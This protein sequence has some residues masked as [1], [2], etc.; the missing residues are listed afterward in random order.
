MSCRINH[1]A[2][3]FTADDGAGFFHLRHH[4][5]LT[6]GSGGVVA[7]VFFGHIAQTTC[8]G[9]VTYGVTGRVLEHIV[10]HGHEGVFF[11]E[12][13]TVFANQGEAVGVGI[14]HKTDVV[15][16]F[17]HEVAN[18]AEI[19]LERF[20]VVCKIA[21]GFAVQQGHLRHAELPEQLGNDDTAH[22]VHCVEGNSEVRT[23][24]GFHVDKLELLDQFNVTLV[25]AVVLNETTEVVDVYKLISFGVGGT[26]HFAGF[27]RGKELSLFVEELEGVP[28]AGV[29][30]GR[31]DHTTAGTFHGNGQFG[32]RRGSQ[33]D[34]DHVEA[35]AHQRT[36]DDLADHLTGDARIAADDDLATI[37]AVHHFFAQAG[38][39]G[40]RFSNIYGVECVPAAATDRAAESRN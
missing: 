10:C 21:G 38:E 13:G 6:Y 17:T 22:G 3:T 15:A 2:V 36:A 7:T 40:H 5:H 33:T 35:H 28:L 12:H 32:R 37:F 11:T 24:N 20:G 4:I 31:D 29:V 25:V 27:R 30:T 8:R 1:T 18:L 16:T 26:H 9:E 39:G 34:V 14:D 23:T 19:L